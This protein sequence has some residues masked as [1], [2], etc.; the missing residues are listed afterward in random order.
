MVILVESIFLYI[1][2]STRDKK[3]EV[4]CNAIVLVVKNEPYNVL[5]D[6]SS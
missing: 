4:L 1:S 5:P 3:N 2:Y 6:Y